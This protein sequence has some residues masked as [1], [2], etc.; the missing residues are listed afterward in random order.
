MP[1]PGAG[2]IADVVAFL[3]AHGHPQV[4]A[5]HLGKTILYVAKSATEEVTVAAVVR[6]DREV[7]EV[8]LI[9]QVTRALGP[10][11]PVLALRPMQ[12]EE[13]TAATGAA[14]GYA[15][16]VAGLKV[17][18]VVADP[19][20]K[21]LPLVVGANRTD[22]HLVGVDLAKAAP[23]QVDWTDITTTRS[24]DLCPRSGT[25]LAERRGIEVGHIFKLGTKY[26]AA[27]KAE[28]TGQD[29]KLHP[30]I[31]GCYGIGTSRVVAAAVEQHNDADGI[32][33]PIAIAPYQV[34]VVPVGKPGD[35]AVEGAAAKIYGELIAAG[36]EAVLDDRDLKPG[37][38][39]KDWDLIGLP[40]R[41]VV[42]RGVAEGV[43]EFKPRTAQ[44]QNLPIPSAAATVAGLVQAAFA[45]SRAAADAVR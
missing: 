41:I 7:N 15:G 42:G 43:V 9:N 14:V 4:T 21:G 22:H 33:W 24:G 23:G 40:F 16:P 35:A 34:V 26:S 11:G 32:T 37:V 19:T 18:F 1:T 3:N 12:P 28:F 6:G 2:A 31:M 44:A 8:K 45:A 30:F 27:M 39:F 36:V 38:K 29:S 17:R 13:V 10:A 25:P 5:A 20:L